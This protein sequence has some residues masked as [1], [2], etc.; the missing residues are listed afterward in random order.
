MC[1]VI[2]SLTSGK[3]IASEARVECHQEGGKVFF[4]GRSETFA[5][6]DKVVRGQ[7]GEVTGPATL[8]EAK[9]KGVN[10]RFPGNNKDGVDCLLTTVRRLRAASAATPRLRPCTRRCPRP[11]R[12]RDSLCRVA[13]ALTACATARAAAHCPL[14]GVMVA[15][16]VVWGVTAW[17]LGG[18]AR[19]GGGRALYLLTPYGWWLRAQVSR[20]A[21]DLTSDALIVLTADNAACYLRSSDNRFFNSDNTRYLDPDR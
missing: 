8:E 17:Q 11:M 12:S 13:P 1:L 10:V 15:E 5:D 20:D 2:H 16:G 3:N 7:Q 6:G 18:S 14:A 21:L 19:E 9:G 4:T